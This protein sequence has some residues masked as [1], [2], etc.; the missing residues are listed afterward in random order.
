MGIFGAMT[1]AISGLQAQ[2]FALE[3]VSGNIA[4][5][6]TTGFKRVDTSFADLVPDLP[7]RRE[8]SGS[9]GAYSNNTA[10]V[11]GDI[12][13]SQI[14]TNMAISGE[15]FFLTQQ[16]TGNNAGARVFSGSTYFTRRGDFQL[17]RDG[18]LV[19]GTGNFLMGNRVDTLTGATIGS[20][21][22]VLRISNAN[23]PAKGTTTVNYGANLPKT[24]LTATKKAGG[25][26]L[27]TPA[28]NTPTI[29][30]AN[31]ATFL[32][33]SVS[34]QSVT[35][36]DPTG[37]PVNVQT[38]WGKTSNTTPETWSLYYQTDTP[39]TPTPAPATTRW[40]QLSNNVTFSASGQ[41]LTPA[42][43]TIASPF[44][45]DGVTTGSINL[46]FGMTNLTQYS[47]SA[48]TVNVNTLSQDGYPTGTLSSV[49]VGEGG[50]MMGT[51]TNG[52]TVALAQVSV[53]QFPADNL[54]KRLDGGL[55]SQTLESGQPIIGAGTSIVGASTEASNVDI[56]DEFSKMIVTQQ[57]YS[58][59]T[60]VVTTAQTMLQ[61]VINIVR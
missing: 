1:T 27:L 6:R 43:G 33:Q 45:V 51:Y 10:T 17:D 18:Y 56:A 59:N 31:E 32:D 42:T 40:V 7:P 12:Q 30:Y 60:R 15:G 8:L 29:T 36:Y 20:A 4:N 38:R 23:L 34:G 57:A 5:S 46:T 39:S 50:L 2:S 41:M 3:N 54:L 44:T 48:G 9:V 22:E 58:A 25:S 55:F 11:Q 14:G 19:N 35:V 21:P 24:P 47:D 49:Q 26:E 13:A 16:P 52:Q 61:D 37:A 28:M 53:A